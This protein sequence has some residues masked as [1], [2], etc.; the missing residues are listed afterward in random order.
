MRVNVVIVLELGWQL[1]ED[2]D[3][4]WPWLYAGIVA[5]QGFDEG[6]ANA[7]ALRA[8]DRRKAWKKAR[9]TANSV[10]SVAV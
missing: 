7:V 3:D 10:V 1:L 5:F 9:A 6:L 4:V 2:G 8:A